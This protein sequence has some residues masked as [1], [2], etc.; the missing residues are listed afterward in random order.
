ML[1]NERLKEGIV[2]QSLSSAY[3]TIQGNREVFLV[4][5]VAVNQNPAVVR[6]IRLSG[7]A[8]NEEGKELERQTIWAGNTI[9]PKIIRGMTTRRHSAFAEL[10][11]A[12]KF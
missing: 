8:Y 11:T 4:T 5:G 6:E 7:I 1:K 2:I 9:S 3:Q 12:Q 10:K